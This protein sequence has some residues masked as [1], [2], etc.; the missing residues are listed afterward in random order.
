M[1]KWPVPGCRGAPPNVQL[2]G[3]GHPDGSFSASKRT[4]TAS[5][6]E[7]ARTPTCTRDRLRVASVGGD[8]VQA[9]LKSGYALS[10]GL[11][12]PPPVAAVW[13]AGNDNVQQLQ[14]TRVSQARWR[15]WTR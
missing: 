15:S 5:R 13:K 14:R 12:V 7:A 4:R 8:A 11:L 10:N 9:R 1:N 3:W 2:W 6:V